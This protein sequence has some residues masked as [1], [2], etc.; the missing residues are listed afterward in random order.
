[1]FSDVDCGGNVFVDEEFFQDG[2]DDVD[3]E[4]AVVASNLWMNRW[5]GNC[6]FYGVDVVRLTT[7]MPLQSILS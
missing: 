7:T 5:V 3:G 4:F 1:M 2:V 6:F